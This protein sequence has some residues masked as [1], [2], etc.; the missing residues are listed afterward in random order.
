MHIV[1]GFILRE[2]AGETVAIPSG[3]SAHRLS[4]LVALNESGAF[5]FRLLQSE[6][7]A[8]G[9]VQALLDNYEIDAATA[10]TDVAEFLA[11]LRRNNFLVETP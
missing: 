11:M 5:L 2:I 7:A 1:S 8:E 4:G 6:Q 10:E 9:L 3:D